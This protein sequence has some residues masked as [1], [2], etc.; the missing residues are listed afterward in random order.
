MQSMALSRR[1]L[2]AGAAGALFSPT[3]GSSQRTYAFGF[4]DHPHLSCNSYTWETF[5]ARE[6]K[7]FRAALGTGLGEVAQSGMDGYEPSIGTPAD[8]DTYAS[9]L[10]GHH[11]QMRSIYVNSTLHIPEE[12]DKNIATIMD[13]ARKAKSAGTRIIVTNP[14]PIRW[15]GPDNKDDRQL[16]CQASALERLGAGLQS[17]GLSL[18]Y[19]NHDIELRNAAREFHH[20][21]AGTDPAKVFLCLDCHWIFRGSGNSEVALFDILKLYGSRIIELHL[22]QSKDGTWTETLGEGDIDYSAVAG[23]L[24]SIGVKPLLVLEQAPEKGT[25]ATMDALQSHRRSREFV[26]RVFSGFP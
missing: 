5:Y 12:A 11:L 1:S 3:G 26:D 13:I 6:K 21:M 7:T 17:A 14:S 19:H 24:K 9:L 8:I 16:R 10:S 20:M 23:H 15:G 2:L 4:A 25:P 18:A 22:R